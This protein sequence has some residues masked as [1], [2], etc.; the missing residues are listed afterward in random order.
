MSYN[1]KK[2]QYLT[3]ILREKIAAD[4]AEKDIVFETVEEVLIKS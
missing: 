1:R 3:A 4:E 2:R